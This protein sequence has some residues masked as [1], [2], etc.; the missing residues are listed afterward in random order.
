MGSPP[1]HRNKMSETDQ[2]IRS[3]FTAQVPHLKVNSQEKIFMHSF[4]FKVSKN[5]IVHVMCSS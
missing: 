2:N 3:F 4:D 5:L 1:K